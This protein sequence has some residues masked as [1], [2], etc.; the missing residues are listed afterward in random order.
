MKTLL[1]LPDRGSLSQGHCLIV[2]TEHSS[3]LLTLDEDVHIEIRVF[4]YFF[5]L[6]RL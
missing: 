2:P 5:T 6:Q 4:I 3:S 1:C